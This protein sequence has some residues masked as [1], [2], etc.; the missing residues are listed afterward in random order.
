MKKIVTLLSLL[1]CSASPVLGTIFDSLPTWCERHHVVPD[2]NERL[3]VTP[4]SRDLLVKYL[5]NWI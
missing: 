5:S 2:H 1:L 3:E 4:K